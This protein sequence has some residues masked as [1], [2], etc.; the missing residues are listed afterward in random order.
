MISSNESTIIGMIKKSG[1]EKRK[2]L[3]EYYYAVFENDR[4]TIKENKLKSNSNSRLYWVGTYIL[5]T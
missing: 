2:N 3:E 4:Y 1:R 5:F